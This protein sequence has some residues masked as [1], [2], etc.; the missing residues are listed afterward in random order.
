MTILLY[1][2]D[3]CFLIA[4]KDFSG[5]CDVDFLLNKKCKGPLS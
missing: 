1:Y 3:L 4:F 2:S 5:H